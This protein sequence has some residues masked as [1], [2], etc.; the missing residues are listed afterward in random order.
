MRS[1]GLLFSLVSLLS[2]RGMSLGYGSSVQWCPNE[3]SLDEYKPLCGTKWL[4]IISTGRA[5]STTI[6]HALRAVKDLHLIGETNIFGELREVYESSVL[7]PQIRNVTILLEMQHLYQLISCPTQSC[8][9]SVP[10]LGGKEVHLSPLDIFFL[11][12]LFPCSRFIL[13]IRRNSEAQSRSAFLRK[14]SA[15]ELTKRNSYLA[16]LHESWFSESK[17]E[18]YLMALED[19]SIPLFNDLLRWIGL[20]DCHYSSI[21][22]FNMNGTY[23]QSI[24][25]RLSGSCRIGT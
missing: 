17:K 2:L 4:F 14:H 13:N 3:C 21:G 12:E 5:G 25:P 19:F 22:H 23:D 8:K 24:G 9:R 15:T 7:T 18:T 16:R 6:L 11:K 1:S 20:H 10:I